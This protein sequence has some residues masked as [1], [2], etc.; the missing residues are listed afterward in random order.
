[1]ATHSCIDMQWNIIQFCTTSADLVRNIF[2]KQTF[3]TKS[4]ELNCLLLI[5]HASRPYNSTF[6]FQ[7]LD[8]H[9]F[10]SNA[11][12]FSKHCIKGAVEEFLS[13]CKWRGKGFS[14]RDVN[15][16]ISYRFLPLISLPSKVDTVLQR[17]LK[18]EPIRTHEDFLA[19]IAMSSRVSCCSQICNS[20]FTDETEGAIKSVS[21]AYNRTLIYRPVLL[22]I[23]YKCI[24]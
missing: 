9:F 8:S 5:R 16:Q 2:L 3:S 24:W 23:C 11:S 17:C 7:Q 10:R 18:R 6:N 19:L 21:S 22:N 20:L 4:S 15:T 12:N 14:R 13:I 1:L